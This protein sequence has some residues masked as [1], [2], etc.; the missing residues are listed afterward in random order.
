MTT[1]SKQINEDK[2]QWTGK[3]QDFKTESGNVG[4]RESWI[5]AYVYID[6][7]NKLVYTDV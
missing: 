7:E 3:E 5:V 4:E 6:R 1:K 2:G